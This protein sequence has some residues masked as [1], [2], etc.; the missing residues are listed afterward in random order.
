M[1]FYVNSCVSN[2]FSL[3]KKKGKG[4]QEEEQEEEIL[5]HK[6]NKSEG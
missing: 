2:E 5:W 6:Q 4:G 3:S 1:G